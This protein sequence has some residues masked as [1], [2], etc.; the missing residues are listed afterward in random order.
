MRALWF[1]VLALPL[2]AGGAPPEEFLGVKEWSGSF[3]I[4]I[5]GDAVE[6]G[7]D[8]GFLPWRK[9]KRIRRTATGEIHLPKRTNSG[10]VPGRQP[11]MKD[12][13][14][15][16]RFRSWFP[17][18]D[19][20]LGAPP[21]LVDVDD[22]Y[23]EDGTL[24]VEAKVVDKTGIRTT[25]TGHDSI[26]RIFGDPPLLIVD[27]KQKRYHL[28]LPYGVLRE[29]KVTERHRE[30]IE[31]WNNLPRQEQN[32]TATGKG[33]EM[34]E[35]DKTINPSWILDQPL[36]DSPNELRGSV[37]Y[38]AP[39]KG[40]KSAKQTVLIEWH[41]SPKPPSPVELILEPE[42]AYPTWRPKASLS[43]ATPGNHLR[44]KA[45]LQNK[46][47]GEPDERAKK[48]TFTLTKVS[49]EP[50]ICI[51]YPENPKKP[52]DPDLKF[53]PAYN[54][55]FKVVDD[56]C[57]SREQSGLKKATAT[58][59]SFDYGAYGILQATAVLASGREI[60]ARLVNE[61][62]RLS[63][64]LPKAAD[65][66]WIADSWKEKAKA[67]GADD[68]DEE[69]DPVGD[70]NKGDGLALYEEYRGYVQEGRW[71][72]LDPHKKDFF[73]FDAIGGKT[74]SGIRLFRDATGLE[75]H[76]RLRS[77]ELGRK[78][79]IN[80]NYAEGAHRTDQHWV[81][82]TSFDETAYAIAVGGPGTPKDI[83]MIRMPFFADVSQASADDQAKYGLYWERTL[84]HE[85]GHAC[86]IYH[87]G[88]KDTSEVWWVD[89]DTDGQWKTW[90]TRLKPGAN[91]AED[92]SFERT[93]LPVVRLYKEP[94]APV[95][96]RPGKRL[97][98]VTI[99]ETNGQHSGF[100]ACLM[101]YDCADAYRKATNEFYWVRGEEVIGDGLCTV[102]TGVTVNKDPRDPKS[103]YGKADGRR[104]KCLMQVCVNDGAD[105]ADR[106]PQ[107]ERA[108]KK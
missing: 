72:W 93:G 95:T 17:Q 108:N 42:A 12:L 28:V 48:I 37:T 81:M 69:N 73:I 15:K 91:P 7:N 54:S 96:P 9:N 21:I 6:S 84:A 30:W 107:E 67:T 104:G 53:V 33:V 82:L 89:Q 66:S 27:V 44:V 22:A 102:E 76:H 97:M 75:V 64:R 56:L 19:R 31:F 88:D 100:E 39:I 50:G 99:G 46:G 85:L 98:R 11:D 77:N 62:G 94:R 14:E 90:R 16:D 32:R 63:V 20:K 1:A 51:N 29:I 58:V 3:T 65:G 35:L 38:Q 41:L 8:G 13:M 26:T 68:A 47:G 59:S 57:I 18:F 43:E 36:P 80:C 106:G 86:N 25:W 78:R 87:H 45:T 92:A 23:E 79:V 71:S 101:R 24:P 105:P 60:Q 5:R 49:R 70:G 4:S 61:P 74:K 10:M 52:A 40:F 83:D 103:R 2:P 55:G 34:P